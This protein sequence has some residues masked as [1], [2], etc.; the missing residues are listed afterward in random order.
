MTQEIYDIAILGTGPIGLEA[1][2]RATDDGY[3]TVVLE[4]GEIAQNVRDWG[5]VKLFSPFGMN[6]SER[7]RAAIGS[8][9]STDDLLT[10][11]AY[12]D[13]YL[14]PL[15]DV[16]GRRATFITQVDVFSV[17]RQGW[18]KTS[19]VGDAE[20]AKSPFELAFVPSDAADDSFD[21]DVP[22]LR[23]WSVIDS[24]GVMGDE[25]NH[26]A[27]LNEPGTY[28]PWLRGP[29]RPEE[30][31]KIQAAGSPRVLLVGSGYTAAT[32]AL[33]LLEAGAEVT[34]LTRRLADQPIAAI[35]NDPL[36]ERRR[37]TDRVNAAVRAG[38]IDWRPGSRVKSVVCSYDR[39]NGDWSRC[40]VTAQTPHGTVQ[41]QDRANDFYCLIFDI[42]FQPNI[43][44]SREL[45]VHLCYATEGPIQLA[46]KLLGESGGDCLTQSGS[47]ASLLVN[48]EPNFFILGAKSYGRNSNFLMRAGIEQ[49]DAV[50]DKLLPQT[51]WPLIGR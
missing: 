23:A 10:G 27:I 47:D 48:P 11:H 24:T 50:F 49:V 43:R 15:A 32:D 22:I 40:Q 41:W 13:Q 25:S 20:R 5:H 8:P 44:L 18:P 37:L 31:S 17:W 38:Q 46:A 16:V 42:G 4:R 34:W 7:G 33:N 39:E 45:H 9:P 1:A 28:G 36:E 21:D 2:L 19:G 14:L 26:V 51:L 35:E 29:L 6:S 12:R 3:K 30:L